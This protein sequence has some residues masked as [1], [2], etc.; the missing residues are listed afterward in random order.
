MAACD[1][2]DYG[3]DT[4]TFDVNGA[5]YKVVPVKDLNGEIPVED[6]I[7]NDDNYEFVGWFWDLELKERVKNSELYK[8][9]LPHFIA[10]AGFEDPYGRLTKSMDAKNLDK[11]GGSG[12]TGGSETG[13]NGDTGGSSGADASFFEFELIGSSYS[14]KGPLITSPAQ[15]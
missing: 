5:T 15:Q 12:G 6:P 10:Y 8:G 3:V 4:L 1:D 7:P 14:V 2:F 13:G 9:E 11:S